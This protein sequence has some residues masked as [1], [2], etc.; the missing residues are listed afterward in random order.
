[1]PLLSLVYYDYCRSTVLYQILIPILAISFFTNP[2]VIS[3]IQPSRR[4]KINTF[5]SPSPPVIEVTMLIH[6]NFLKKEMVV[7]YG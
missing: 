2:V 1:M 3:V 4:K 5:F 6:V 7:K